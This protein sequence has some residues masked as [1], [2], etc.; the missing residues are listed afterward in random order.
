MN[1]KMNKRK[2]LSIEELQIRAKISETLIDVL[3]N[4]HILDGMDES[5]QLSLF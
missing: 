2:F 4:M 1:D 5:N 3:K